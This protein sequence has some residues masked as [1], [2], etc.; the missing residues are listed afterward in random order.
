MGF[1][2]KMIGAR[3]SQDFYPK[4]TG[5]DYQEPKS[6]SS[7]LQ[8]VDISRIETG[9]WLIIWISATMA[10][11][12]VLIHKTSIQTLQ[13]EFDQEL[14]LFYLRHSLKQILL[15][16]IGLNFIIGFVYRGLLF[17]NFY[18]NGGLKTPINFLTC[19]FL[20]AI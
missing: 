18:K 8:Q 5:V 10:L 16:L 13:L 20:S 17:K 15:T 19:E 3:H 9:S 7:L 1:Q 14:T 4:F 11:S 12:H 6:T 2:S